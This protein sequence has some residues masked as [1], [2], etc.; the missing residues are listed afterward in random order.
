MQR[1]DSLEK[2]LMLE[3][4]GGGRRRGWQKMRWLDGITNSTDMRLSKLRESVM[5]REAWPTLVH[6]ITKSRTWLSDWTESLDCQGIPGNIFFHVSSVTHSLY[7]IVVANIYFNTPEGRLKSGSAPVLSLV[8]TV[9]TLHFFS[10]KL[11]V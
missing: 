9:L 4:I 10:Q 5:D 11:Q 6:G 3:K 1:T 7:S 2:S 8:I